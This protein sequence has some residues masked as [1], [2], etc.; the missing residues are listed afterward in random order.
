MT[1]AVPLGVAGW[2]WGSDGPGSRSGCTCTWESH[3]ASW[4]C[5]V[6]AVKGAGKM[7]DCRRA[8]GGQ[9]VPEGSGMPAPRLGVRGASFAGVMRGVGPQCQETPSVMPEP[10]LREHLGPPCPTCPRL[11]PFHPRLGPGARQP[12]FSSDSLCGLEQVTEP[13]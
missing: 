3:L 10:Q 13:L 2:A 4:T 5:R 6:P 8:G 9:C 12:G 7:Q 1:P 11:C